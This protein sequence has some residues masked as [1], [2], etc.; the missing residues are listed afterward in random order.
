LLVN[1]TSTSVIRLL[2]PY[3]ATPA[4]IDEAMEILDTCVE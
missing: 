2:P 4:D 1:R 3:I